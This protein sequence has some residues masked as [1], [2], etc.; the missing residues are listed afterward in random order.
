MSS[1]YIFDGWDFMIPSHAAA[2]YHHHLVTSIIE[3]LARCHSDFQPSFVTTAM[4]D[5]AH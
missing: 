4:V 1:T 5:N 2:P 3:L